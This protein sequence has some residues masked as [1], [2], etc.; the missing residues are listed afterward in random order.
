[1]RQAQNGDTE[2]AIQTIQAVNALDIDRLTSQVGP[3]ITEFTTR[4]LNPVPWSVY[5][6]V[7]LEQV[8]LHLSLKGDDAAAAGLV[9]QVTDSWLKDNVQLDVACGLLQE[10]RFEAAKRWVIQIESLDVRSRADRYMVLSQ[11]RAGELLRAEQSIS[12]VAD[13]GRRSELRLQ[14][15][16]KLLDR[17]DRMAAENHLQ[18]VRNSIGDVDSPDA[19]LL[20]ALG[21]V[22]ARAGNH[23]KAVMALI[24]AGKASDAIEPSADRIIA[25]AR[26]AAL[27]AS[28]DAPKESADMF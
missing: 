17:D 13:V 26:N 23:E 27:L 1:M 19:A 24:A 20:Y 4:G 25:L 14:L 2:A 11:I 22:E 21:S 28:A 5:R 15:V 10:G 12:Q 18:I 3:T 7:S 8:A 16:E 6:T 9:N